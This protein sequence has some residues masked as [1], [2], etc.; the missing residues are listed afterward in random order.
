VQKNYLKNCIN[1][2][3]LRKYEALWNSAMNFYS[4]NFNDTSSSIRMMIF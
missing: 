3:S 1:K 2:S 4:N